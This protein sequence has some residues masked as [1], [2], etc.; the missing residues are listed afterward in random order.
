[1]P[2]GKHIRNALLGW[3]RE[4]GTPNKDVETLLLLLLKYHPESFKTTGRMFR[5]LMNYNFRNASG[6]IKMLPSGVRCRELID[7]MPERWLLE[8]E[9]TRNVHDAGYTPWVTNL[10]RFMLDHK[11]LYLYIQRE[12]RIICQATNN[13]ELYDIFVM[14][15]YGFRDTTDIYSIQRIDE[16]VMLH[17]IMLN[18]ITSG[19]KLTMREFMDLCSIANVK[20]EPVMY[21]R[22]NIEGLTTYGTVSRV[23]VKTYSGVEY[24]CLGHDRM[25]DQLSVIHGGRVFQVKNIRGSVS[26]VLHKLRETTVHYQGLV[27]P[28]IEE[29]FRTN[30]KKMV[31]EHNDILPMLRYQMGKFVTLYRVGRQA[32]HKRSKDQSPD[33]ESPKRLSPD[34]SV[35]K[36]LRFKK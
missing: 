17:G 13:Q 1:M 29:T 36:P 11:N 34:A 30:Y 28:L 5:D 32:K 9:L 7:G 2:S 33:G 26:L 23:M 10:D 6:W 18:L 20:R 8:T 4:M 14:Y 35:F 24:Q 12:I 15:C 25:D 16:M 31:S 19:I 22:T 21:Y 27:I 3:F